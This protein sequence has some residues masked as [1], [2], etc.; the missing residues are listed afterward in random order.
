M[1]QVAGTSSINSLVSSASLSTN[2]PNMGGTPS[3]I[4]NF[5]T[6]G[7]TTTQS[8]FGLY[9]PI[10]PITSQEVT[11][12][13]GPA[14]GAWITSLATNDTQNVTPTLG[15]PTIDLHAHEP[16]PNFQ[17]IFFPASP[18]TLEH[19]L[20][21]GN[22]R[23][24]LNVSDQFRPNDSADGKGTQRHV[25][26]GTTFEVLYGRTQRPHRAAHLRRPGRLQLGRGEDRRAGQR[27][28]EPRPPGRGARQ[29]RFGITS[30]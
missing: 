4:V 5:P 13:A 6:T 24:Y 25:V 20:V 12:S 29:R 26:A 21:F 10:L 7:A 22:D 23:D 27:S 8:E 14:T 9:R 28:V 30:S 18:F 2:D 1:K 16:V 15:Y 19:S 17:P 11:S 3:A